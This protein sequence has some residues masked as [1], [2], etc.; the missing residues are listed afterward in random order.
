MATVLTVPV[1]GIPVAPVASGYGGQVEQ[2]V[3]QFQATFC[4]PAVYVP[5]VAAP[6]NYTG[7]HMPVNRT[8]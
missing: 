4:V 8:I 2:A 6:A 7:A 3:S 1:T 5:A